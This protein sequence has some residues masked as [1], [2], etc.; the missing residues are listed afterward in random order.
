MTCPTCAGLGYW[1]DS[2]GRH[3][4][5]CVIVRG[6]GVADEPTNLDKRRAA[7][8][9][10]IVGHVKNAVGNADEDVRF[11]VDNLL[12]EWGADAYRQGKKA[13]ADRVIQYVVS[14]FK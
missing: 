12:M 5:K 7:Y 4:C 2:N 14:T 8:V 11:L 13:A 10:Q 6:V 3:P 1:V 9:D